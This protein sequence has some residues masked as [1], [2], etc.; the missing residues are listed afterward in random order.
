MNKITLKKTASALA[1]MMLLSLIMPV[2]AFAAVGFGKF[3]LDERNQ[4]VSGSVYFTEGEKDPAADDTVKINVYGENGQVNVINATY[5]RVDVNGAV[6]YN[7]SNYNFKDSDGNVLESVYFGYGDTVTDSVYRPKRSSGGGGGG[8][9]FYPMP[10]TSSGNKIIV[11]GTQVSSSEL[12]RV[13]E[14]HAD[15][16]IEISGS[17]VIIPAEPLV[18]AKKAH[19]TSNPSVKVVAPDGTYTLPLAALD[20]DDLAKSLDTDFSQLAI[21]V[22]IKEVSEDLYADL[23]KAANAVGAEQFG[24]AVEFGLSAQ[25]KGKS[26]K[27]DS[28]GDVFVNRTIALPEEV[29]ADKATGAVYDAAN[30]EMKFVP[31]IFSKEDGEPIVTIKRNSNSIYTVV[32]KDQS[33]NDVPASHW[34]A[35]DISVL[36]NKLI[37]FGVSDTQFDL[38]RDIT[39]AEFAGLVVRSLGLN[40]NATVSQ[41]SDVEANKWYAKEIAAAADA[42]IVYGYP[43]GTFRPNEVIS[44]QE[45]ASMVVR[46]MEFAGKDVSITNAKQN[47][48]LSSYKDADQVGPW[49][50][51]EMAVA[52]ESEVVQGMGNDILSPRSNATRGQATAMLFRYLLDVDFINE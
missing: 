49:A 38:D 24:L 15:V 4:T 16:I 22:D 50:A 10:P 34:A 7:F 28:F 26:Q 1:I 52:L 18:N 12:S 30:G 14:N 36:T 46:A 43:D 37:V 19:S 41:F 51:D 45:L 3:E 9:G 42:G 5:D 44:R 39:R 27:I 29:D 21:R 32:T 8:G 2:M 40:T 11:S 47:Q 6:Y 48:L 33:F 20:F 13:F 25:A 35:D 23:E 31:S 17:Y